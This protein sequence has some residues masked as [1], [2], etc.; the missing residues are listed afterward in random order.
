M[1]RGKTHFMPE[2]SDGDVGP[3]TVETLT[4]AG[5]E[6]KL[7]RP[8][9][10]ERLLDLEKVAEAYKHDEYMP[11][12]AML[13]PVAKYLASSILTER[14]PPGKR[15]IELGCGLGLPGVA[16][17]M[18]GLDVTFTD[19]DASALRFS[20]ENAKLNG[21]P[22]VRTLAVDWREPPAE[23]FDVV[24]GSDLIYE[25][26]NVEPLVAAI[27]RLLVKGG[28]ALIADQNRQYAEKFRTALLHEGFE[29]EPTEFKADKVN[30]LDV[31]GTVYK[32]FAP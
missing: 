4:L 6:L 12:W 19:Y 20:A 25:A 9:S 7:A 5:R 22:R 2:T 26:R 28:I 8:A 17:L 21:F 18:A 3:I 14:F 29:F 11:Y 13:W 31:S 30:G 15:A 24:L 10:P 1:S 32:I 23:R 27:K 16:G